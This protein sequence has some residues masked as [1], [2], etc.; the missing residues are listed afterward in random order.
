MSHAAG[1]VSLFVEQV[2][3]HPPV[4]A[5]EMRGQQ[6]DGGT[7]TYTGWTLP[8]VVPVVRAGVGGGLGA[9]AHARRL[10]AAGGA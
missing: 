7:W 3:H 8:A 2:C 5:Y 9:W 1:G 10:E 6:A 4:S